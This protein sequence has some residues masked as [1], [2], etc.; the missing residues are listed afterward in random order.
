MDS[1]EHISLIIQLANEINISIIGPTQVIKRNITWYL[2]IFISD[3]IFDLE[4]HP[5]QLDVYDIIP[6]THPHQYQ[7]WWVSNA[8]SLPGW[9]QVGA[10]LDLTSLY[11]C[12]LLLILFSTRAPNGSSAGAIAFHSCVQ[13]E[14]SMLVIIPKRDFLLFILKK[15][16]AGWIS[17]WASIFFSNNPSVTGVFYKKSNN[18]VSLMLYGCFAMNVHV[19]LYRYP[20][21]WDM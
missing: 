10:P 15:C 13:I 14:L 5:S 11:I 4:P 16:F 21:G 18:I 12:K 2:S 3:V 19:L 7:S 1:T 9:I 6:V 17:L 20:V 8:L